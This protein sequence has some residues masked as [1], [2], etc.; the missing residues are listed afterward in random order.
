MITYTGRTIFPADS[1][2]F[3]GE[4]LSLEDIAIGLSAKFRFGR[5]TRSRYSVL[6]HVLV[7]GELAGETAEEHGMDRADVRL[8]RRAALLHDSAEVV[9]GDCVSTWKPVELE[10]LEAELMERVHD[11]QNLPWPLPRWAA[12][13]VKRVDLA[14][15]AA[16]AHICG[17]KEA[18]KWWPRTQWEELEERAYALTT[19]QVQ[20]G[21]IIKLFDHPEIAHTTLQDAMLGRFR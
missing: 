9:V 17:H 18:S 10:E 15:L 1:E 2:Y 12:K 11:D 4:A 19:R 3:T 7:C 6:C 13:L 5:M 21:N 14:T 20:R 8:V 16:E